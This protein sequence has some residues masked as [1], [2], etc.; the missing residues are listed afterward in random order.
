M[1]DVWHLDRPPGDAACLSTQP[2][3]SPF[4]KTKENV[5]PFLLRP[6]HI[7]AYVCDQVSYAEE[8][9]LWAPGVASCVRM[10][11]LQ[12]VVYGSYYG[13]SAVLLAAAIIRGGLQVSKE[14]SAP[15]LKVAAD[16]I[17]K[18]YNRGDALPAGVDPAGAMS[19]G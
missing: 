4:E 5:L 18:V 10:G 13:P 7:I 6:P 16:Y 8:H 9:G 15:Q 12:D 2:C 1:Y 3:R 17:T 11:L 14:Y 19:Y